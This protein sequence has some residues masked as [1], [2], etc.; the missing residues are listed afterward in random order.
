ML[1]KRRG[2]YHQV[3]AGTKSKFFWQSLDFPNRTQGGLLEAL[4]EFFQ[5]SYCWGGRAVMKVA[6][7]IDQGWCLVKKR[8]QRNLTKV[9][10]RSES[11]WMDGWIGYKGWWKRGQNKIWRHPNSFVVEII[12]EKKGKSSTLQQLLPVVNRIW[13]QFTHKSC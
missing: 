9:W 5:V 7:L 10:L 13:L 6:V 4:L 1:D 2:A 12:S 8:A 3:L 11:L